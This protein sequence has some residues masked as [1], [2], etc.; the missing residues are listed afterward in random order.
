VTL[1]DHFFKPKSARG[2]GQGRSWVWPTSLV[3]AAALGALV[4]LVTI[5]SLGPTSLTV[6]RPGSLQAGFGSNTMTIIDQLGTVNVDVWVKNEGRATKSVTC[7]VIVTSG[8]GHRHHLFRGSA[9]FTLASI[10]PHESKHLVQVVTGVYY[11]GDATGPIGSRYLPIPQSAR[12]GQ[13]SFVE[14]A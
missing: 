4:T 5:W 2:T 1:T 10:K 11:D 6:E 14:C 12:L 3:V 7:A 13:G 8:T 9:A